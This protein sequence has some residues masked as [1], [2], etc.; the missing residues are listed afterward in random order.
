MGIMTGAILQG[1][2]NGTTSLGG[3]AMQFANQSEEQRLR[4]QMLRERLDSSERNVDARIAAQVGKAGGGTKGVI[5]YKEGSEGEL[6]LAQQAGLSV[7]EL[8]A[9][10]RRSRTGDYSDL[11]TEQPVPNGDNVMDRWDSKVAPEQTETRLSPVAVKYQR[12]KAKQLADIKQMFAQ[13]DAYDDAMKGKQTGQ[14]MGIMDDVLSGR[15]DA[16]MVARAQGAMKGD[17]MVDKLGEVGT[18]DK[19]DPNAPQKLNA[20]GNAKTNEQNAKAAREKAGAKD[21][22]LQTIQQ[23]RKSA[24][25]T[26]KSAQKELADFDKNNPVD[27]E[28]PGKEKLKARRDALVSELTAARA[29]LATVTEKLNA[30]LDE[31]VAEKGKKDQPPPT[32]AAKPAGKNAY[33][34]ESPARPT[35]EA[36][37]NALPSGA[38]Y[39]KDGK[40]Y[41]KK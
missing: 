9:I 3:S 38:Y 7:P 22:S 40:T 31:K 17:A 27:V 19:Y 23:L 14:Q 18:F 33:S 30:R 8:R 15:R 12:D 32:P 2:G 11:A 4:E 6:M 21:D 39:I 10:N 1:L 41:R 26:L 35:S 29:G 20:L 5:D 25:E 36:E 16:N 34:A 28:K 13:G 37:Y 24:E